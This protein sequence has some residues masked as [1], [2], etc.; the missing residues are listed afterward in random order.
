MK[1]NFLYLFIPIIIGASLAYYLDWVLSGLLSN[2]NLLPKVL[3]IGLI[4]FGLWLAYISKKMWE[5]TVL[6]RQ[7]FILIYTSANFITF[8]GSAFTFIAHNR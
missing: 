4:F 5:K 2:Y 3:G 8:F 7:K 6:E 1:H